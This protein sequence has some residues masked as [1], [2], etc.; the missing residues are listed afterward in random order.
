[1]SLK[2]QGSS[3]LNTGNTY[4]NDYTTTTSY[5]QL[6]FGFPAELVS[7]ANDSSTDTV[8]ISWDGSELE[9]T[10]G[11]AEFKDLRAGGRTSVYVKA[12][13]GS[14]KCRVTAE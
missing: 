14:E 6:S 13:T 9:Y 8:Q 2:G 12:T 5:V 10:L 11:A 4:H 3:S 1:M 7:F